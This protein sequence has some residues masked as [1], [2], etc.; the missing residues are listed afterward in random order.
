MDPHEHEAPKGT[1]EEGS[2]GEDAGDNPTYSLA[3]PGASNP[4]SNAYVGDNYRQ[5]NP[6][7]GQQADSP[8]WSL[9]SPLPHIVRPGM[10]RGA[11]PEDRKEDREAG[12]NGHETGE[13]KPHS[14]DDPKFFNKW[15]KFRHMIREP[16]A[17]WLGI[18][19][20]MLIGL[21]ATLSHF[22]SNGEAGS[23]TSQSLAWGMGFCIGIYISGGISGGQ[24]VH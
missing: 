20:A 2:K 4:A 21:C 17:E 19:V 3:G 23:Y 15:S 9:A 18:T 14:Q 6:Q 16:L 1:Q 7:Y 8:T 13:D 12:R 5:Y 22:T 10:Q 24:L 11:L